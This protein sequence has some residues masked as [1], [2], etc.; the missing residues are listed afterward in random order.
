MADKAE[1]G[2]DPSIHSI[3][4][5][6]TILRAA[7]VAALSFGLDVITQQAKLCWNNLVGW[8]NSPFVLRLVTA[9]IHSQT[10]RK[11]ATG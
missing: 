11:T 8:I 9:N 5:I 2:I 1:N 7:H 6:P 4:P 3:R 10:R